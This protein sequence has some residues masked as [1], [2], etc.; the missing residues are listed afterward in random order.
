MPKFESVN[1]LSIKCNNQVFNYFTCTFYLYKGL[2][3]IC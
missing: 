3:L 1:V 2:I